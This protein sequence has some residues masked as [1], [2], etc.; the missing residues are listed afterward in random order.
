M[1]NSQPARPPTATRLFATE[2][3]TA[4]ARGCGATSPS[5]AR[6]RTAC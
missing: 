1:E 2:V 4:V 3:V 6:C 5:R